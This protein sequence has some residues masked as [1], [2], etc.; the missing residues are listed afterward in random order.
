MQV[1]LRVALAAHLVVAWL[2]VAAEPAD[3]YRWVDEEGTVSY[4]SGLERVP[5]RY[6]KSAELVP[7]SPSPD[8][9][10]PSSAGEV[11]RVSF[12]P[13]SA[14]LVSARIGGAGP[15]TLILDTGAE[16]TIVAPA[17][18]HALGVP[19]QAAGRTR[20]RGIAGAAEADLMWVPSVE[21]DRARVGPIPVVAY[22]ALLGRAQGLLGRDFLDQ[23]R[24]T[25]DAEHGIVT[26]APLR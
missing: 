13:G 3:V 15:V 7:V 8:P 23:F 16:R 2:A 14:I 20:I 17:T 18:L 11:G 22:D 25:I 5:E 4:A 12:T 6:R 21:V 26:L 19:V 10:P 9:P 24:V 1:L